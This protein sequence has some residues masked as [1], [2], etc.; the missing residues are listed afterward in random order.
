VIHGDLKLEKVMVSPRHIVK[1]I[2]FGCSSQTSDS[3]RGCTLAYAAPEILS[4]VECN[5]TVDIWSLGI[6]LSATVCGV[7]PFD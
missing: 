6:I 1:L 2:D 4:G 3:G 5:K 7:F